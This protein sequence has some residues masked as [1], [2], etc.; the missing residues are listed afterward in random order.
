MRLVKIGIALS[1]ALVA[2]TYLPLQPLFSALS[3]KVSA[4][5]AVASGPISI[6]PKAAPAKFISQYNLFKD[7]AKQIPNDGLVPYD[8]NTPLFSDYTEK[9]RFIYMPEG[10][11]A[12]YDDKEVFDF[13]VG[14]CIV[15]T[16]GYLNDIRDASKG[17]KILETRLLIRKPDGWIGLPYRWNAD[18]SDAKLAVAGGREEASWIHHDGQQRTI[19]YII[20]NMNQCKQCHENDKVMQP[21]GPKA[22]HL[23]KEHAFEGGVENQLTHLAKMGYLSGLPQDAASVPHLPDAFDPSSGSLDERARAYLD[24]NCAH[25]H[26]P[27]GPAFV[28]GLDLSYFQHEPGRLGIM[29]PPVAAGRGAGNNKVGILPGKPDESILV[30]RLESTDPGVMM[31]QLPRQLVHDEGLALVKEW[32]AAMPPHVPASGS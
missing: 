30:Y 15:K 25:C 2:A 3:E 11:S 12:K 32:I 19:N 31:P 27:K 1:A 28:S 18:M 29:K 21:I 8:L 24:I 20:P 16:F 17:E 13:P 9:H 4:K 22:R 7:P 6:D 5:S 26:N 23:N 10:T 14:T